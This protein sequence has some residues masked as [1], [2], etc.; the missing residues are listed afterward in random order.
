MW[1]NIFQEK[2]KAG[3]TSRKRQ[4]P[5]GLQRGSDQGPTE[6]SVFHELR[7]KGDLGQ[8][9]AYVDLVR[10]I[11]ARSC[12]SAFGGNKRMFIDSTIHYTITNYLC[13]STCPY[14]YIV[15]RRLF[16][17]LCS[18]GYCRRWFPSAMTSTE[19]QFRH[20]VLFYWSLQGV[21]SQ[22]SDGF[23]SLAHR[24]LRYTVHGIMLRAVVYI[25]FAYIYIYYI[26]MH[27]WVYM[28]YYI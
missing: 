27:I 3:V 6:C 16:L 14:I 23:R 21:L 1:I 12:Q 7:D 20:G 22:R 15:N 26:H 25:P 19:V 28:M 11:L 8:C 4:T 13:W 9:W 24:N 10:Y 2:Q 5:W 17:R 18:L